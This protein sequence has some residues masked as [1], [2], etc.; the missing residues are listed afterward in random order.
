[1]RDILRLV[2]MVKMV[3][4][5]NVF[6]VLSQVHSGEKQAHEGKKLCI[7]GIF[8]GSQNDL[9]NTRV[10]TFI[11]SYGPGFWRTSWHSKKPVFIAMST[12]ET[13]YVASDS[14]CAHI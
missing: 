5:F 12:A 7:W 3:R 4:G 1:M 8:G 11:K 9:L 13:E 2:E 14:C 6:L 10:E